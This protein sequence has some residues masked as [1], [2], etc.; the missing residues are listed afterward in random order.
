MNI[1]DT[2]L[3]I[4][5]IKNKGIYLI[6]LDEKQNLKNIKYTENYNNKF[7]VC[8]IRLGSKVYPR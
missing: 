4:N 2:R 3:L 1:Y 7:P 5:F 8:R 6:Q